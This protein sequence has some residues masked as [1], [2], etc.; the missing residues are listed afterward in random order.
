[1]NVKET[2]TTAKT[3]TL[4]ETL[5]SFPPVTRGQW[6]YVAV[7][8]ANATPTATFTLYLTGIE[9]FSWLGGMPSAS[10]VAVQGTKITVIG[11]GLAKTASF[12]AFLNGGWT[13]GTPQG[14]P[15]QGPS[16]FTR[17]SIVNITNYLPASVGAGGILTVRFQMLGTTTPYAFPNFPLKVGL[18]CYRET[19]TNTTHKTP[20]FV[21]GNGGGAPVSVDSASLGRGQGIVFPVANANILAA[22]GPA[23]AFLNL[24]GA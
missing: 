2:I 20:I 13:T 23:R 5:I 17:A 10:V 24:F 19:A 16:S 14:I 21:G 12:V 1:M 4:G 18:I 9:R 7:S 15:P 11:T 6:W 22:L 3:N 8:I